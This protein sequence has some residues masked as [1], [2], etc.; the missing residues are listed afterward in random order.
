MIEVSQALTHAST[1]DVAVSERIEYWEA[2]NASLLTGIRCSTHDRRGLSASVSRCEVNGLSFSDIR[3]NEHIVERTPEIAQKQPKDSVFACLLVEG[4]AFFY[5]RSRC[6][7]LRAGDVLLYDAEQPF[8]YGFAGGM[9]QILIDVPRSKL[10]ESCRAPELKAP[11][12]IQGQIGSGRTLSG[13]LRHAGLRL[14]AG[15]RQEDAERCWQ[16]IASIF[17][18]G[19]NL[20][21]SR[22]LPLVE[23][24]T[25]ISDHLSSPGLGPEFIA[26]R[27]GITTRHLNRVFAAEEVSIAAYIRSERLA[28]AHRDLSALGQRATIGEIAY[29]WGFSDLAHF[30]RVFRQH[31]GVTP[32]DVRRQ[33]VTTQKDAVTG[34]SSEFFRQAVSRTR[35]GLADQ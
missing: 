8:L 17:S 24:K 20:Q 34:E 21:R 30:S 4:S 1:L 2:F 5:Q 27:L 10:M 29:R 11:I 9:R 31:F 32:S 16:L 6:L 14:M 3:G 12:Q 15:A 28:A 22:I 33:A 18:G 25:I 26:D 13:S 7:N 23:I 35:Y 19:T